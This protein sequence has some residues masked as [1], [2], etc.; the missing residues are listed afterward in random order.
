MVGSL[1]RGEPPDPSA[2]WCLPQ[3]FLWDDTCTGPNRRTNQVT[4]EVRPQHIRAWVKTRER[5]K[6]IN[7]HVAPDIPGVASLEQNLVT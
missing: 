1:P 5:W 6:L 7:M 4:G 3:P 2:L